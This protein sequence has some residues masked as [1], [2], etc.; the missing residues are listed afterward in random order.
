MSEDID[1]RQEQRLLL[2]ELVFIEVSSASKEDNSP[3]NIVICN[4]LDASANGLQVGMDYPLPVG[5]IH[6]LGVQLR[7]QEKRIYLAAEVKWCEQ[8]VDG[9]GSI[10]GLALFESEDTDIQAWKELIAERFS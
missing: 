9:S 2:E 4:T 3:S 5:S 1:Q 8:A 10:M 7:D 6:Q